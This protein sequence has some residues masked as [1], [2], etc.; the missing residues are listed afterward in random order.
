MPSDA[1]KKR[2]AAKK[3]AAKTRNKAR[4]TKKVIV[5]K[6]NRKMKL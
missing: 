1:K 2:D 4:D 3:M 5:V 6:S